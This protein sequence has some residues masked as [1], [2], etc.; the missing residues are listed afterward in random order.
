M[1][2]VSK[3]QTEDKA[4]VVSGR[5]VGRIECS[6]NHTAARMIRRFRLEEKLSILPSI[7]SLFSSSHPGTKWLVRPPN[8]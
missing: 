4:K 5:G 3:N 7:R 2:A 1:I 6:T 8:H